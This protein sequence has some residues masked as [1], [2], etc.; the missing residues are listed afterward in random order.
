MQPR[1]CGYELNG[2]KIWPSKAKGYVTGGERA[3]IAVHDRTNVELAPAG[4]HD[5]GEFVFIWELGSNG[6]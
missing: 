3:V 4:S 6:S 1:E 2:S 5:L